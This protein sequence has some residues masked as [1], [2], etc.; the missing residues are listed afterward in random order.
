M[1]HREVFLCLFRVAPK[2][3]YIMAIADVTKIIIS[4]PAVSADDG[5]RRH[6]FRD[7]RCKRF[8][9]AARNRSLQLF[10]LRHDTEPKTPGISEFLPACPVFTRP[11]FDSANYRSL[12]MGSF[13]FAPRPAAY[14]AFVYLDR[15]RRTDVSRSG[16]TIPARS[17]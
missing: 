1:D 2:R 13:S 6:I 4:L 10:G 12:M 16:R 14:K 17:L 5:V 3:E 11:H 9:V 7:E 8:D 15:M